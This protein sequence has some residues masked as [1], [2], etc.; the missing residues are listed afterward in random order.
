MAALQLASQSDGC[1][2]LTEAGARLARSHPQ[3][4]ADIVQKE[5]FFY[6]AWAGLPET[7]LDGHARISPWLERLHADPGQSLAFLRALD[8]LAALFGAELAELAEIGHATTLLDVGGGASSH[9]AHLVA[10]HPHLQATVL[11]RP[12]VETLVRERHPELAFTAGDLR[13]QRFGRP[14]G[15]QWGV[16]LLANILHDYPPEHC[17]RIVAEAAQLLAPG[18][19][20][21]VYEWLLDESREGPTAV[22]LFALMMLVENEGGAAYTEAEI[23][24]WIEAAGLR[25]ERTSRGAG[26]IAAM[27][28]SRPIRPSS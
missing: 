11:D 8:D 24:E 1:Y 15:E 22:A 23:S 16:L 4:I 18:G 19:T 12:E 9:G 27:I 2:T 17:R 7:I 25:H 21:L 13:E 28:G 6:G 14:T 26:P 5:W 3:T 20:F 10:L